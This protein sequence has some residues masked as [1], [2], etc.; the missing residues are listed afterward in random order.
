MKHLLFVMILMALVMLS[1]CRL[2]PNALFG[3][4]SGENLE[5]SLKSYDYYELCKQQNV[6]VGTVE[7]ATGCA[8]PSNL[9]EILRRFESGKDRTIR[10]EF[11]KMWDGTFPKLSRLQYW[12]HEYNSFDKPRDV[13]CKIVESAATIRVYECR[14]DGVIEGSMYDEH[15][16]ATM[17]LGHDT[18][19]AKATYKA[20]YLY[21]ACSKG[22][23]TSSI[24]QEIQVYFN[25]ERLP[26]L[27]PYK[28]LT[29]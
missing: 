15:I 8:T 28:A 27:T 5:E 22:Q 2:E 3:N 26:T 1:A 25:R 20:E 4:E 29:P 6:G 24:S 10:I 9:A 11:D 21:D 16:F 13:T 19:S 12:T 18:C 17:D 14:L 7:N 23:A